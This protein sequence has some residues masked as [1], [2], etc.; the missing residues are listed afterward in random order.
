MFADSNPFDHPIRKAYH[1]LLQI[2]GSR[3]IDVSYEGKSYR[4]NRMGLV[5]D[6]GFDL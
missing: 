4:I 3:F 5:E 1:R 6:L 2:K